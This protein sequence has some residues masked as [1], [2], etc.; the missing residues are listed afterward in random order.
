MCEIPEVLADILE[1]L[2]FNE[3]ESSSAWILEAQKSG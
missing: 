2:F 1:K 3:K